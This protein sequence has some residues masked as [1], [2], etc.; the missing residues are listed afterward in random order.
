VPAK[1]APGTSWRHDT[2]A[3]VSTWNERTNTADVSTTEPTNNDAR[4]TDPRM[5]I[6][7]ITCVAPRC[8]SAGGED[9]SIASDQ[10]ALPGT[11]V[12]D[13]ATGQTS[14][15]ASCAACMAPSPASTVAGR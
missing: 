7:A 11:R 8:R 1:I 4:D 13:A 2:S 3:T 5:S 9:K 6:A 14:F 12:V 10:T 15:I